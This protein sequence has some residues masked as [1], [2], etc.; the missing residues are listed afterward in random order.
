MTPFSDHDVAAPRPAGVSSTGA[1]REN[2]RLTM[3]I[4]AQRD[5]MAA[6]LELEA[7]MQLVVENAQTLTRA[8][9]AAIELADG[10]EM[11][12]RAAS[13]AAT[14]SVGLRLKIATSL[15]GLCVRTGK[16]LSCVDADL[17]ARVDRVACRRIGARSLIVVPLRHENVDVGVLKVMSS[18]PCAK[19]APPFPSSSPCHAGATVTV[20]SSSR[21][22]FVMSPR[23]SSR[24]T[25]SVR[26]R[27][28]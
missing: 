15:S 11:V 12:Y 3:I 2:A 9:A 21:G 13:G 6:G 27:S 18:S 7:V 24:K 16:I 5:V 14:T 4:A 19:A 25:N 26:P 8:T 20:S 1:S 22:S 17:D 28:S 23:E 10:D